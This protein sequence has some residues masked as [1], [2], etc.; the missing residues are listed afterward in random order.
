MIVHLN[1]FDLKFV[2]VI[3]VQLVALIFMVMPSS[4]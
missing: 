1:R 3:Y 2:A 4:T